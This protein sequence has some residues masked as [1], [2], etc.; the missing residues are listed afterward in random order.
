ML[1]GLSSLSTSGWEGMEPHLSTPMLVTL[2]QTGDGT[3]PPHRSFLQ[4]GC[5]AAQKPKKPFLSPGEFQ[6]F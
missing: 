3:F 6:D 4:A 2:P 1:A 5:G